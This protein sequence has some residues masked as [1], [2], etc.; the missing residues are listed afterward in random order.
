MLRITETEA[1]LGDGSD[2]ASHAHSGPTPRNRTMFGPAGRLYVYRSYGIHCCLNV[3]CDAQGRGA[4]VLI[5][6]AAPEAGENSMRALRGLDS[7]ADEAEIAVGPGRLGKAIG[8][9]LADDG[10]SLLRGV[11]TIHPPDDHAPAPR[12]AVGPRV[13]ITKAADLPYR[14]FEVDRENRP[15]RWV[16]RFRP[17]RSTRR[18]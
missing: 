11:L 9:R 14:F 8:A 12:I 4:A 13:G 16:S 3:V 2:P 5:R 18:R 10:C 17:G 1:Y 7:D 6:A 15:T